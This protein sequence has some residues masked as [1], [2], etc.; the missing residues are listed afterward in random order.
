MAF[1]PKRLAETS[2]DPGTEEAPPQATT[3]PQR[4]G[5]FDPNRL[6]AIDPEAGSGINPVQ[7]GGGVVDGE[8]AGSSMGKDF[9]RYGLPL[10]ADVATMPF[11]GGMRPIAKH[12]IEALVQGIVEAGMQGTGLNELSGSQFGAALGSPVAGGAVGQGAGFLFRKGVSMLPGMEKGARTALTPE[13]KLLAEHVLE[14]PA[15]SKELYEQLA[16][17]SGSKARL[18]EFPQLEEA[19]KKI[20]KDLGDVSLDQLQKDL[21]TAGLGNLVDD[22]L[23]IRAGKPAV[24]ATKP[25]TVSGKAAK[26]TGLPSSQELVQE[27]VP[28]GMT[29]ANAKANIEGMGKMIANTSDAEKRGAY[30]EFYSKFLGDMETM[31]APTGTPVELW[32]KARQAYKTEKSRIMLL[33]AIEKN[34]PSKGGVPQLNADGVINWMKTNKEFLERF[35]TTEEKAQLK[36]LQDNFTEMA[37]I[38]GNSPNRLTGMLAGM[39]VS[40]SAGGALAGY[41]AADVMSKA[42]MTEEGGKMALK[43]LRKTGPSEWYHRGGSALAVFTTSLFS[44]EGPTDPFKD[45]K[46][47]GALPE[48][49]VRTEPKAIERSPVP[50]APILTPEDIKAKVTKAAKDSKL[51]PKLFHAVVST[52]SNYNPN[53]VSPVGAVGLTQLMPKTAAGLGV[54]PLLVD[55]NLKGGATYLQSLLKKYDGDKA[56]AIAAYNAGPGRVDKGGPLPQETQSYVAKIM[57]K[58]R[59]TKDDKERR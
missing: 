5:K 53:A 50:P 43:I 25:P 48:G 34:A 26:G 54:N 40:H 13:A 36:V 52:E 42:L 20:Q 41:A 57:M 59:G 30:K 38:A 8:S 32:Q 21:R 51:D 16:T 58:L 23:N 24:Y 56:K 33:D 3:T 11:T 4:T 15:T 19:A 27:A 7:K 44:E 31:E 46:T 10:A 14:T 9:L 47:Y 49:E 6:K 17:Q 28:P 29:F 39:M 12:G 2:Y 45:G 18:T 35:K 1:D 22:I 55:E 37:K